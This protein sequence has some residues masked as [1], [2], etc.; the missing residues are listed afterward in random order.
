[1]L[2]LTR[3]ISPAIARCELTHLRRVPIDLGRAREQHAEYERALER[4]GCAV[5]RLGTDDAMPD[6]VFIEDTAVV[7][8]ELA[9][10]T[11]PGA[12]SRR[13]ERAAVREALRDHRSIQMIVGPGTIDGGD[14]MVIGRRVYIGQSTRTN[15]AGI[16]QM[17]KCVK[18]MGYSVMPVPVTKCLH[19]KSA[20]TALGSHTVLLNP[21]WISAEHFREYD[22]VSVDAREPYAANALMIDGRVIYA[23][24]FPRTKEAIE[25]AGF[26]VDAVPLSE[27]A[28]AEG[29]VTCGS[30]IVA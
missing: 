7:L 3:E 9:I 18:P 5:E 2:A 8:K 27:L 22:R 13:D 21:E 4:A 24:E 25:R 11:R 19:L 15:D 17:E 16:A 28:K 14:V 23:A 6:S 10:I 12:E 20:V 30:L 29:A 26:E 1:M